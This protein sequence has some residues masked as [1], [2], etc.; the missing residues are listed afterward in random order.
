MY[1]CPIG[2]SVVGSTD[3]IERQNCPEELEMSDVLVMGSSR[4]QIVFV[5]QGTGAATLVAENALRAQGTGRQG[6]NTGGCSSIASRPRVWNCSPVW[7]KVGI[8][9]ATVLSNTPTSSPHAG[10]CR[11]CFATKN[12]EG[13]LRKESRQCAIAFL[14]LCVCVCVFVCVC[15][16]V[17]VYVCVIKWGFS[18]LSLT[19]C[20]RLMMHVCGKRERRKMQDASQ[21]VSVTE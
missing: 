2:G 21:H 20:M 10:R 8:P 1:A 17:C 9:A 14:F 4:L 5:P 11:P 6:C 12:S 13:S 19:L 16:C 3:M 15:V 18:R 7:L